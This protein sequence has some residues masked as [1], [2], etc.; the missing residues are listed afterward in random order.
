MLRPSIFKDEHKHFPTVKLEEDE[1]NDIYSSD[2]SSG[3][4]DDSDSDST[5]DSNTDAVASSY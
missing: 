5:T 1:V 2:L 4:N 3:V